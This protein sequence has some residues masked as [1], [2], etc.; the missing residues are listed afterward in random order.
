M[1][2]LKNS[3]ID[4]ITR[5]FKK[6]NFFCCFL[7]LCTNTR[8]QSRPNDHFRAAFDTPKYFLPATLLASRFPTLANFGAS[9]I[10]LENR[11]M[12]RALALARLQTIAACKSHRV[13]IRLW[14]QLLESC[15][16][17]SDG[18]TP[19]NPVFLSLIK[20]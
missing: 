9:R 5:C 19:S 4:R 7:V 3:A 17:S 20:F 11:G 6:F 2:R 1:Y 12:T 8:A 18:G 13:Y 15:S 14:T 16:S 10:Y